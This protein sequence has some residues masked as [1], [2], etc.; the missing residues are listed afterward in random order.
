LQPIVSV[1]LYQ[2]IAQDL[3]GKVRS[4]EL[5]PGSQLPTEMQLMEAYGASRNTV[6]SALSQLQDMGMISR[7]RNRGTRVEGPPA[8]GAFTQSM[9][10]L[11]DLVSLART[12]QR[13]VESAR[14]EVLDVKRARELGC[15][16]GSR[17]LHIAM[18]R[19]ASGAAVPLG[20]T[21]AYVDPHYKEL[22]RL[23]SR[24]PDALLAD[25]IETHYGRRIAAVEQTISGCVLEERLA[26]KLEAASGAPGLKILRQYRDAARAVV[27]TT[28]SIY[29]ADRYSVKTTLVRNK[30]AGSGA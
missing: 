11:D 17:W 1:T 20:W 8:A 22:R 13:K 14:E 25:L 28:C 15:A 16:P 21:D 19:H 27:L 7:R 9:S 29:P 23:A 30:P 2:Q 4:G 26:G 6:R 18:T 10:T 3:V 12:A 5:P 24:H